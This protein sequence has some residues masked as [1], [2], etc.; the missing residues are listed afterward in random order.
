MI[1]YPD[2]G[3]LRYG[4]NRNNCG[5]KFKFLQCESFIRHT[6]ELFLHKNQSLDA[7]CGGAAHR[8]K[9]FLQTQMMCTKTLYNYVDAGLLSIAN[10]DLPLKVKRST[11]TARIKTHKNNLGTSIDE[12]PIHINDRSEFGHWEIDTVIGKKDKSDAVLLAMT[13]RMTRKE[14]IRKIPSKSAQSVQTALLKLAMKQVN[15]FQTYLKALRL[16][17]GLNLQSFPY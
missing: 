14:I 11:K 16:T 8:N 13:E 12:H 4:A 6:T 1:Y 9:S 17:T 3:Q 2:T 10:I 5:T 15:T 7:I